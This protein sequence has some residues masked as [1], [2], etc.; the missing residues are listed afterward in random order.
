[1]K[2]ALIALAVA[3]AVL[4]STQGASATS[5]TITGKE[6]E[7]ILN[8]PALGPKDTLA[9]F[10]LCDPQLGDKD[11]S[12]PQD[13]KGCV[14]EKVK[15]DTDASLIMR[16]D[17]ASSTISAA[18][19]TSAT[20]STVCPPGQVGARIILSGVVGGSTVEAI[21]DPTPKNPPN[22]HSLRRLTLIGPAAS[23]SPFASVCV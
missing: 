21:Y 22:S 12:T 1:M 11:S 14:K 13:N 9:E 5:Q 19:A 10:K 3:L 23:R 17:T 7:F 16:V 6:T 4:G 15:A 18:A 20:D 2:K 8:I